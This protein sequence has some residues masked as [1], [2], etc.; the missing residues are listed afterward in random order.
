MTWNTWISRRVEPVLNRCVSGRGLGQRLVLLRD[1]RVLQIDVGL[2]VAVQDD[3]WVRKN[4]LRVLDQLALF[5]GSVNSVL[6]ISEKFMFQY[7]G[8]CFINLKTFL[9]YLTNR[10]TTRNVSN[11]SKIPT[12]TKGLL[13][14]QTVPPLLM[15]LCGTLP[16]V[17]IPNWKWCL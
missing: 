8:I 7:S 16:C 5:S 6:T 11:V 13:V 12:A 15:E 2:G 4:L 3:D 17:P 1:D 14:F 10:K 9:T